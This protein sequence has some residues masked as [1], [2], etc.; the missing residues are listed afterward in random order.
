MITSLFQTGPDQRADDLLRSLAGAGLTVESRGSV[1]RTLLDTFDRRLHRAGLVL[2]L[3][4]AGSN[5]LLLSAPDAPSVALAVA[6]AHLR[7]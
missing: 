3:T 5:H 2:E 1:R 6:R 4:E 7:H